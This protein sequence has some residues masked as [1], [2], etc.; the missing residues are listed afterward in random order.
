MTIAHNKVLSICC[1]FA[2]AATTKHIIIDTF[3]HSFTKTLAWHRIKSPRLQWKSIEHRYFRESR[4]GL[5]D[6]HRS[7]WPQ[8]AGN[9][10]SFSFCLSITD[11]TWIQNLAASIR[12]QNADVVIWL[13]KSPQMG[14][15]VNWIKKRNAP[16]IKAIHWILRGRPITAP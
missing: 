1:L 8:S 3:A 16:K 10:T 9:D 2:I 14:P 12:A 6:A 15:W 13:T 7:I 11:S 5:H 4:P